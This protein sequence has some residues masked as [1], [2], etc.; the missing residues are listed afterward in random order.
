MKFFAKTSISVL[1]FIV[2]NACNK[3]DSEYKD[4]NILIPQTWY[5][6][7]TNE[8]IP[9]FEKDTM[10]IAYINGNCHRCIEELPN[11]Q[12]VVNNNKEVQFIF[13]T[14]AYDITFLNNYL[15]L[16][17]FSES[18]YYDKEENFWK[19]NKISLRKKIP[20]LLLI[21]NKVLEAGDFINFPQKIKKYIQL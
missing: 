19:I 15:A 11:W 2:T 20:S 21:N 4:Q 12:K 7:N 10:I 16:Y 13:F 5:S 3:Y 6:I 17:K 18:V 14:D 1:F 8:E 9:Q